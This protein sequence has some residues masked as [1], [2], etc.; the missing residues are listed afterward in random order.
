MV[1]YRT[2]AFLV[3]SSVAFSACQRESGALTEADRVSIRAAIDDFTKAGLETDW[4]RAASHYTEDGIILPPNAPV[5]QGRPAI[6]KFFYAFPKLT[7]FTQEA[8]EIEGNSDLAYARGTGTTAMLPPG[9]KAAVVDTAKVLTVW[10]KQ[11]D[12]SWQVIRGMWNSDLAPP[13]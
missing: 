5:V 8:V 9:A 10:R 2:L 4:R 12:G 1:A 7:S 13:K 6:E 11:S 3:I